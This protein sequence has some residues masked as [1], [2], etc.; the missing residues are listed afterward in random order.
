MT[1]NKTPIVR[2]YNLKQ[3]AALY[4]V[5]YKTLLAWVKPFREQIGE[6]RG[7]CLTIPQVKIIFHNLDFPPGYE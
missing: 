3:L 6:I 1:E 7:K 4:E 5:S 2:P